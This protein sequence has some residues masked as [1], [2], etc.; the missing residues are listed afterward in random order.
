MRVNESDDNYMI[1]NLDQLSPLFTLFFWRCCSSPQR[2]SLAEA[3][4]ARK[5]FAAVASCA[6]IPAGVYSLRPPLPDCE[7]HADGN[8]GI[9]T[10]HPRDSGELNTCA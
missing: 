4:G 6:G 1:Y 8:D 7:V 2:V 9:A 10:T 5:C 3:C